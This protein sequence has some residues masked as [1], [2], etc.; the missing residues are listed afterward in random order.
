MRRTI[1]LTALLLAAHLSAQADDWKP[2][3]SSAGRFTVTMPGT[4]KQEKTVMDTALGKVDLFQFIVTSQGGVYMVAY[5]DYPAIQGS[6]DEILSGTAS[7]LMSGFGGTTQEDQKIS[8]D[9]HPGRFVRGQSPQFQVA[10]KVFWMRPR[11]YE[12]ITVMPKNKPRSDEVNR[13]LN[14]F[15]AQAAAGSEAA[16]SAAP[17]TPQNASLSIASQPG[18]AEVYLDDKRRGITGAEEGK[19]VLDDLPPGGYKLRLS[20][21]AIRTGRRV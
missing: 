11:L 14:S 12:L 3:S 4:P 10:A 17:E 18:S 9:G 1:A 21:A 7:G 19:L 5:S 20:L 8:L 15:S 16:P 13:F 6:G 2:Y